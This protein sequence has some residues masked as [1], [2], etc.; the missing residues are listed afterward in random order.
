MLCK[1][2][3]GLVLT[4]FIACLIVGNVVAD[5]PLPEVIKGRYIIMMNNEQGIPNDLNKAVVSAGGKLEVTVPEI[6]MAVA[7]SNVN[8]FADRLKHKDVK[9]VLPDLKIQWLPNN[10][11]RAQGISPGD[12]PYFDFQWN[13]RVIDAPSAWDAGYTG[14]GVRVADLDTGID[15]THQDLVQNLDLSDSRSFV[16]DEPYPGGPMFDG[17]GHGTHTAGLIA[18]ADNNYGIIGVAPEATIIA[19]KVLNKDGWGYFE[20][21]AQGIIYAASE[22]DADVINMSLAGYFPKNGMPEWG[23]PARLA[24]YYHTLFNR[25]TSFAARNGVTVVC[26]AANM[27]TN[28]NKDRNWIVLPAQAGN[29]MAISA[30]GP[31]NQENFDTPAFYTN[32]GTSVISVAAPGGNLDLTNPNDLDLVVSCLPTF[33][34]PYTGFGW[35]A[36]T[37]MATPH[38]SGLA[39]LIIGKNGGNMSPAQVKAI[40]EQSADDLGKPGMDD[41]YGHGRI[42]A[43][44]AVTGIKKAPAMNKGKVNPVGKLSDTWGTIKTRE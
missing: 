28:L 33:I 19:V 1:K 17:F 10:E 9:C 40:I 11:I 16:L 5:I 22:A 25:S 7:T 24:A 13:M 6:G 2:G 44:K 26:A 36:G 41:F 14:K 18:A 3:I 29:V 43:Y 39:A 12:E 34:Y 27:G 20:W 31:I 4:V 42:N 15:P 23:L 30:T 37:S 38:V 8:G 32:Y 35:W 21:I